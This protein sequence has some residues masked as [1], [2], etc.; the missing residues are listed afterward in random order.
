MD[1][2]RPVLCPDQGHPVEGAEY[3]IRW[4][5]WIFWRVS[6]SWWVGLCDYTVCGLDSSVRRKPHEEAS[7]CQQEAVTL[8]D[9]HSHWA[10]WTQIWGGSQGS[11][12]GF[13]G[14]SCVIL[15]CLRFCSSVCH[16][17]SVSLSVPCL[18]STSELCLLMF[19]SISSF[20]QLEVALM[21]QTPHLCIYCVALW[22]L[23]LLIFAW[24]VPYSPFQ[25][26]KSKNLIS[27]S[28][29]GA[30]HGSL[31]GLSP[32]CLWWGAHLRGSCGKKYPRKGLWEEGQR[33]LWPTVL[34][35]NFPHAIPHPE[36][37]CQPLRNNFQELKYFQGQ[38]RRNH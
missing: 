8:Q 31:P 23:L 7:S 3:R 35:I 28:G 30:C 32:G 20:L 9:L 24:Y 10:S 36:V 6:T 13:G 2:R 27:S 19:F 34:F 4:A 22:A 14:I 21:A 12:E 16:L 5:F 33:V 29:S 25:I 11:A 1:Q 18:F 37:V 26:P 17:A 15:G 38:K